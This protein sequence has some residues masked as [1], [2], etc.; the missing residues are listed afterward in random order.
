MGRGKG[1]GRGG[2]GNEMQ[3]TCDSN[4]YL[5]LRSACKS[6]TDSGT[7][8]DRRDIAQHLIGFSTPVNCC[9]PLSPSNV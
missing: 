3:S 8:E 4:E 6:A 7:A 2:P 5:L 1:W 9:Y